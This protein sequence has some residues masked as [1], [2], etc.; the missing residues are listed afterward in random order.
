VSLGLDAAVQIYSKRVDSIHNAALDT[1]TRLVHQQRPQEA[2]DEIAAEEEAAMARRSR[3]RSEFE[4]DT[5]LVENWDQITSKEISDDS[6]PPDPLFHK[7]S[8]IFDAQGLQGTS[9]FLNG[10]ISFS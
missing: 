2:S 10:P 5:T 3:R 8:T 4:G 7:L 1:R 6:A 9:G